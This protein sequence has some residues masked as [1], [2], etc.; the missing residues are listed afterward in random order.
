[1]D[2]QKFIQLLDT[3]DPVIRN[4]VEVNISW[5]SVW[6]FRLSKQLSGYSR[7]KDY[8]DLIAEIRQIESTI[9]TLYT[10]VKRNDPDSDN[11]LY[12]VQNRIMD[13]SKSTRG[14]GR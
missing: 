10:E 14:S 11:D 7:K 3:L 12:K 13:K 5:L 8:A 4:Q 6:L 2:N 1:M 9:T